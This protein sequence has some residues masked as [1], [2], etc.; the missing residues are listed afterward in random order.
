MT[1]KTV[2]FM[3]DESMTIADFHQ[4]NQPIPFSRIPTYTENRD[5]ITGIV[6][7]DDILQEL[8]RGDGNKK[9]KSLQRQVHYV[10]DYL[11]L[12]KLFDELVRK[13]NHLSVVV[14]DFGGVMGLVTMEDLF[15]TMIGIEIVDE[16]DSV[17]DLQQMARKKWEDRQKKK[18]NSK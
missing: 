12:P 8:V 3:V 10:K 4:A 17:E 13:G 16:T 6:L 15:E 1:P 14:D 5:Q 7:K 9:I 11:P 18:K 2:T